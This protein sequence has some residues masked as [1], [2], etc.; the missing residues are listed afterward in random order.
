[1]TLQECYSIIGNYNEVMKR[2]P[3]ETMVI[4]FIMKFLDDKSYELLMT[5]IENSDY[6]SA[7]MAS[8]TIKGVCQN[9]SFTRLYNSSH[10]ITEAL[11]DENPDISLISELAGKVRED[12]EITVNAIK[13][14]RDEQ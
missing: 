10:L 3:R 13:A 11:R 7:F 12:Y 9:L 5:S 6:K 4:K 2:L 14:F 8:H 1:M